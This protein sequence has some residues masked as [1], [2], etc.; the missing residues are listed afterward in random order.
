MERDEGPSRRR[1]GWENAEGPTPGR[2][3][4]GGQ[5]GG[6][7]DTR[8][9]G[10]STRLEARP[11]D[12]PRDSSRSAPAPSSPGYTPINHPQREGASNA[13]EL[14]RPV[15]AVAPTH[16]PCPREGSGIATSEGVQERPAT[17]DAIPS[18][19][20]TIAG[21]VA[22]TCVSPRGKV[23]GSTRQLAV[24]E[25]YL[26]SSLLVP[27]PPREQTAADNDRGWRRASATEEE[28]EAAHPAQGV[29]PG[30]IRCKG[31]ARPRTSPAVFSL[32]ETARDRSLAVASGSIWRSSSPGGGCQQGDLSRVGLSS[33]PLKS[34]KAASVANGP[35]PGRWY[36]STP[37]RPREHVVVVASP[38]H[39]RSPKPYGL[40]GGAHG[41]ASHTRQEPMLARHDCTLPQDRQTVAPACGGG[42]A[43]GVE[44]IGE[45][46]YTVS[47]AAALEENA[48]FNQNGH[49]DSNRTK[50]TRHQRSTS[51]E[52]GIFVRSASRDAAGEEDLTA[53]PTTIP[54][55][56]LDR[57]E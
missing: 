43:S 7:G 51:S 10:S 12:T 40:R 27:T 48:C 25:Q 2:E 36:G 20:C 52:S 39:E 19:I 13:V 5:D 22:A 11:A 18:A 26:N 24:A 16:S 37:R 53:A 3:V 9:G 21:G 44:T 8:G 1:R 14:E 46:G 30:S 17:C 32:K 45:V 55:L 47:S 23:G 56:Q 28:A 38:K 42:C 29:I 4:E 57:L 49:D 41:G 34:R 54:K 15:A 6:R 33:R 35:P 31:C 50:G